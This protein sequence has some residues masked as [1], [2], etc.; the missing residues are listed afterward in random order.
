MAPEHKLKVL[1][2]LITSG[3]DYQ[4]EQ[5]AVAERMAAKL[6]LSLTIEYAD[7]DGVYETLQVLKAIQSAPGLR[8]DAVVVEPVGTSMVQVAQAAAAAGIGW[9]ILNR[10]A[11]YLTGLRSKSSVPIFGVSTDNEAVGRIQGQQM[12]ALTP[13]GGCVLYLEGPTSSDVSRHRASGMLASKRPDILLKHLRGGWT[14]SGAYQAIQ[15]WLQLGTS[16]VTKI[17]VLV[18]QNDTMAMGARKAFEEITDRAQRQRFLALPFVGCDG[19]PDKGQAYVL[20]GLLKA[21]VINPPLTG[22]ALEMLAHAVR[23][24]TQPAERTLVVPHPFPPLE[25]LHVSN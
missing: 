11:D 22:I 21:T 10:D 8:P 24:H 12:N 7:S 3:T 4:L 17:D 13:P 16:K 20:A 6:N 5:A 25:R 19:V 23:S 2:F 9:A 15:S 14:E 1:V 18:S